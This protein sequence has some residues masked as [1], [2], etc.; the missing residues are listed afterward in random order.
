M[1]V[2]FLLFLDLG[3]EFGVASPS[4]V[5]DAFDA[6]AGVARAFPVLLQFT[7]LEEV[8]YHVLALC[9]GG[10][11]EFVHLALPDVGAVDERLRV[12]AKQANDVGAHVAGTV[13]GSVGRFEHAFCGLSRV[14]RRTYPAMDVIA[15]ARVR[16]PEFDFRVLRADGD[17]VLERP[18][19]RPCAVQREE[20]RF[21]EGGFAASVESVDDGDSRVEREV[22]VLVALEV[23]QPNALE[24][25]R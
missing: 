12:H 5:E 23:R 18:V 16:E 7:E 13:E 1:E 3:F 14:A 19:E 24:L 15:S 8:V 6:E 10:V 17:D 21:E 2:L 11:D 4:V 20:T 9:R 25:H 22:R